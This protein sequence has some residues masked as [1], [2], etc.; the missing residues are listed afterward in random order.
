VGNDYEALVRAIVEVAD[1]RRPGDAAD[2]IEL[3]V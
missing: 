3:A 2:V 1:H